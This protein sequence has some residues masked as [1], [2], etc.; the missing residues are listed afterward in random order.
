MLFRSAGALDADDAH[1]PIW[2]GQIPIETKFG[3]PIP[4]EECQQMPLPDYITKMV[5]A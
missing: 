5:Q 2:A 1:L 4:N 3:K